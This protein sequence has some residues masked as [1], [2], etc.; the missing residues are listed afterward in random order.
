MMGRAN[1]YLSSIHVEDGGRAVSAALDV[2]AGTYNVVDDEP[3]TKK[4]YADALANAVGNKPWL[5]FPG[6]LALL[7]GHNTAGLTN[8]L[9]VSNRHFKAN[10]QWQPLYPSAREGWQATFEKLQDSQVRS[11]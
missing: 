9:R 3:L 11:N 1:S 10:S 4:A 2:P 8:S 5:R 6:R 7:L